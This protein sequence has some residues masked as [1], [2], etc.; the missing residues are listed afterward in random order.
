MDDKCR[1]GGDHRGLI[2]EMLQATQPR[3]D[4]VRDALE[5]MSWERRLVV[6]RWLSE[7]LERNRVA[8]RGAAWKDVVAVLEGLRSDILWE[9]PHRDSPTI[10]GKLVAL[11][12]DELL[13]DL[14]AA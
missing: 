11:A 13:D 4:H 1:Y 3:L 14:R 8:W 12:N 6:S 2:V 10:G 7:A 5:A 9:T